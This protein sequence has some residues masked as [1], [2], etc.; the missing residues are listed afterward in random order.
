M[1]GLLN[2]YHFDTSAGSYQNKYE[3][4]FI[5]YLEKVLHQREIKTYQVAQ[6]EFP[7][8]VDECHSWIITGSPA[9]AYEDEQWIH[10][11]SQFIRDCHAKKIKMLGI[12]FGHQLIAHALG[13]EVVNSDKGW[14]V[15]VR[16][17]D[18]SHTKHWMT[19][20]LEEKCSLL[21][22]HQDQVQTLP[23]GAISLGGDDFCEFQMYSIDEH[24]FSI[25][26]HPEFTRD[27]AKERYDTRIERLGEDC[28][29]EAI[30][31]LK[32]ETDELTVGKWITNFLK[33]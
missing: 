2:A 14:G 26:G 33:K 16:D 24:V 12:C 21:F 23:E 10:N 31:S 32:K 28:H 13:G 9:S 5:E 7:K 6:N 30:T 11:L 1:I 15:G 4:I 18:V 19:P 25:Q 3:P 8:S 17:F 27:Y 20:A 29:K 22:S